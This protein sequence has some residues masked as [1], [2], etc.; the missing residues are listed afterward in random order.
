MAGSKK[1]TFYET[2]DGE[3]WGLIRDES[4]VEGVVIADGDV[5]IPTG[6]SIKYSVPANVRPRY[7]TYKSETTVKVRRVTI[8]TRAL[9]DDLASAI[10]N[11]TSKTF[12][13]D[14][15]VFRLQGLSPERIRPVVFSGDTGLNDGDAT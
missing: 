8:P 14:G 10:P 1:W 5:D 13:E 15:E 9:Y 7:A 11:S 2:D 4:N 12:T 6:S 3:Q